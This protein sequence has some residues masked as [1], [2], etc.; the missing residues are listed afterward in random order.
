MKGIVETHSDQPDPRAHHF[1]PRALLRP[2]IIEVSPRQRCLKGYYWDHRTGSIRFKYRGVGGFCS[3]I[4]L[5]TLR[6]RPVRKAALETEFFQVVDDSG[7]KARDYMIEHG[8]R[9]LTAQQRSDF[10]RLLLSLEVRRPTNV[11]KLRAE[12]GPSLS[13]QLD[14][15]QE[16]V[17]L[18]RKEGVSGTPS[19]FLVRATGWT[20]EDR[21]LLMTQRLVDNR[22]VGIRLINA[23]WHLR[24]LRSHHGSL[25]IGDR[26]LIRTHGF[27]HE[28][29]V[30]VLPLTPKIAFIAANH[31]ENR[32]RLIDL[33]AANFV[34]HTNIS[35]I[36]QAE[37]F[38]FSS[39][40]KHSRFLPKY[41]QP[42]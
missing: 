4:D 35:T 40:Q 19:E 21:A 30:W 9:A 33:S 31:A 27:D 11:E 13:K 26:P 3:Q 10:A 8:P 12:V 34:K 25:M 29:A 41:L 16:V 37:R 24:R 5:L 36:T 20:F 23:D 38:V 6:H 32:K 14:A 18:M 42:R 17:D 39:D 28:G 22:E 1:V 2:W 15:D 7:I